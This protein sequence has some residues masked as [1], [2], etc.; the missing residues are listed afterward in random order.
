MIDS[1]TAYTFLFLFLLNSAVSLQFSIFLITFDTYRGTIE[2]RQYFEFYRPLPSDIFISPKPFKIRQIGDVSPSLATLEET[3]HGVTTGYPGR[4]H[5]IG[6]IS[7]RAVMTSARYE[8][9]RAGGLGQVGPR[10]AASLRPWNAA[11]RGRGSAAMTSDGSVYT[12]RY[13]YLP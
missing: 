12:S 13:S 9:G 3:S 6:G 10:R 1:G 2:I 5:L 8:P 11:G 7:P 4:L